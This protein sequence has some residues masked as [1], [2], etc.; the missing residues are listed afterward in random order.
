MTD[1][2]PTYPVLTKGQV[3]LMVQILDNWIEGFDAAEDIV[4]ADPMFNDED[5]LL[6][7][8][9]DLMADKEEACQIRSLLQLYL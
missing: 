3:E 7:G 2:T 6:K 9:A 4:I 5:K 1:D 8:H